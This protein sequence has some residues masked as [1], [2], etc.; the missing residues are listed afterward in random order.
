MAAKRRID[1]DL[2]LK[3]CL[4]FPANYVDL[5]N[6]DAKLRGGD[7]IRGDDLN[8][9]GMELATLDADLRLRTRAGI[10]RLR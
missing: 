6:A 7:A 9:L 8:S 3:R 1:R 2:A 4:S 10:S 5:W